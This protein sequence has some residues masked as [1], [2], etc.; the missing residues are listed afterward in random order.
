MVPRLV[1]PR[2]AAHVRFVTSCHLDAHVSGVL[3]YTG[4]SIPPIRREM[5]YDDPAH[6]PFTLWYDTLPSDDTARLLI[7]PRSDQVHAVFYW[8][9]EFQTKRTFTT[10]KAAE[11][12]GNELHRVLQQDALAGALLGYD[13]EVLARLQEQCLTP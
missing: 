2:T 10:R 3:D 5:S 4:G 12:W 1:E 8:N 7:W 11:A 6:Q 9:Q 13:R